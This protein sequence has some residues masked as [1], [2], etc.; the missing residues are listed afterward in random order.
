MTGYRLWFPGTDRSDAPRTESSDRAV[1]RFATSH[2]STAKNGAASD[3]KWYVGARR[4]FTN[5]R[6]R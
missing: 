3:A 2:L 6:A 5:E 4:S 1:A